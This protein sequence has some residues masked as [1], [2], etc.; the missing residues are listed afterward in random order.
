MSQTGYEETELA[1]PVPPEE[2]EAEKVRVCVW[3]CV[4]LYVFMY[5]CFLSVCTVPVC[6]WSYVWCLYVCKRSRRFL[7]NI[8]QDFREFAIDIIRQKA[9][10]S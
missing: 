5:F 2:Q 10:V 1:Y 9:V 3:L 4:W 8:T 6:V 7:A